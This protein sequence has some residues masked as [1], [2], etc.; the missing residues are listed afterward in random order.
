LQ[1]IASP[2]TPARRSDRSAGKTR[3]GAAEIGSAHH[4]FLQHFAL[5]K[6]GDLAVEAGRLVRE[7][8]LTAEEGTA[9]DLKALAA[10]WSSPAGQKILAHAGEVRRELPFTARFSPVELAA[11]TGAPA[12]PALAEEFVIVQ[13]VADLV[14]LLPGEIW[15]LDFKTDDLATRELPEKV[16]LYTPQLRLYAAA[17]ERIFQRRVTWCALHFLAL[18]RTQEV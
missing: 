9:L 6:A 14:V 4:K 11:I 18:D 16:R 13:G 1:E 8:Y 5:D 2:A 17:L 15:L 7:N 12:D 10:F 3:L